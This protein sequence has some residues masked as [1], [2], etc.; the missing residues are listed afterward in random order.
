M[1]RPAVGVDDRRSVVA[2]QQALAV[3]VHLVGTFGEDGDVAVRPPPAEERGGGE[4]RV[5][6]R[7][8]LPIVGDTEPS[9]DVAEPELGQLNAAVDRPPPLVVLLAGQLVV[10]LSVQ[11]EP[12]RILSPA[13]WTTQLVVQLP[14][15]L[16]GELIAM[17]HA[18]GTLPPRRPC[19]QRRRGVAACLSPV[20]PSADDGHTVTPPTR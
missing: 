10:E 18:T 19:R 11:Q 4:H 13:E 16:D 5:E 8:Q 20:P 17:M 14:P 2:V 6:L 3:T 15:Q 7:V 12:Q 1:Q 9:G